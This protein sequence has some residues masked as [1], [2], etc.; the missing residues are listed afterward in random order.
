MFINDAII[1]IVLIENFPCENKNQLKARELHYIT[2]I[3][4]ININK[5][6]ICSIEI[7]N[8]DDK[9]WKKQYRLDHLEE[10]KQYDKHYRL[11]HIENIKQYRLVHVEQI[12]Q[13]RLDHAEEIKQ[14]RKQYRL[15]HV[16]EIKQQRK[17]Y[18]LNKKAQQAININTINELNYINNS[19]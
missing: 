12:K 17:R 10:Q 3:N 4:C 7:T 19:F 18:R 2:T 11:D 15:D 16:E 14:Q 13:Y 9:E 8:G 6:F 5:P 1:T